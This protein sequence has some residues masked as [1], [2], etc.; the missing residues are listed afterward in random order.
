MLL[1]P[2][3][4]LRVG[5]NSAFRMVTNRL[6]DTRLQFLSGSAVVEA[7]EIGKDNSVTVVYKDATCAP[8]QE[9]HLPGDGGGGSGARNRWAVA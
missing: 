7:E 1:T 6:I 2:G 8:S 3:V 9:R 5:E 4:F